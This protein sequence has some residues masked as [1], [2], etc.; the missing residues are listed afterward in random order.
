LNQSVVQT[1]LS[2][3]A[4]VCCSACSFAHHVT[5]KKCVCASLTTGW[6][7]IL[8]E[9]PHVRDVAFPITTKRAI[10]SVFG[11]NACLY[12]HRGARRCL[13]RSVHKGKRKLSW[14]LRVTWIDRFLFLVTT[15]LV[16]E[17]GEVVH[18]S[19]DDH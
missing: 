6:A 5:G 14:C 3:I 15:S 4:T 8:F 9:Q 17:R 19:V 13:I 7:Q 16:D 10:V 2:F 12:S 11:G 18:A 1:F